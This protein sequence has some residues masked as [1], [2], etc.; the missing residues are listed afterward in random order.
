ML[1]SFK[2]MNAINVVLA[3][4]TALA[5]VGQVAVLMWEQNRPSL[6]YNFLMKSEY[7]LEVDPK[8]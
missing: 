7:G 8:V 3:A 6:K 1:E 5:T 2:S 4:I